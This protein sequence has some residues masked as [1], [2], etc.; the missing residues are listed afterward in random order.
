M[1]QYQKNDQ[2]NQKVGKGPKWTFL[3]RRQT[4]G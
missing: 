4:D 3:Q 2:P 1:T